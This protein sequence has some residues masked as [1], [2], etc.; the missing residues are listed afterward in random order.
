[1]H[2]SGAT[3]DTKN[4]LRTF[5]TSSNDFS[6]NNAPRQRESSIMAAIVRSSPPRVSE[7]TVTTHSSVPPVLP[8][9]SLVRPT[10]D[11][12]DPAVHPVPK[13][14]SFAG[15]SLPTSHVETTA[16]LQKSPRQSA[17]CLPAAAVF[18]AIT[19]IARFSINS[20]GRPPLAVPLLVAGVPPVDPGIRGRPLFGTLAMT[21]VPQPTSALSSVVLPAGFVAGSALR[22]PVAPVQPAISMTATSPLI[23]GGTVE[24]SQ[25]LTTNVDQSGPRAEPSDH[26]DLSSAINW[27]LKMARDHVSNNEFLFITSLLC[28]VTGTVLFLNTLA[29]FVLAV[30]IFISQLALAPLIMFQ[31]IPVFLPCDARLSRKS[32]C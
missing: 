7:A 29:T 1:M 5:L 20:T 32:G 22:L 6:S 31:R 12:A 3:V 17:P 10:H 16:F 21:S 25:G 30:E 8:S 14:D 11:T 28:S 27:K 18:P 15:R 13:T 9:A 26:H 2:V 24:R 23:H 19:D 4:A